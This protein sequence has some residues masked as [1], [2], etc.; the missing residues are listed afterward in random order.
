MSKCF[1][2]GTEIAGGEFG[3]ATCSKCKSCKHPNFWMSASDFRRNLFRCNGCYKVFK[4]V[5]AGSEV[6]V[7]WSGKWIEYDKLVAQEKVEPTEGK[8]LSETN[9][10]RCQMCGTEFESE[11]TN[12][13]YCSPACRVKSDRIK[14]KE[15]K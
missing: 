7:L 13:K 11:R 6:W 9:L 10:K 12:A 14:K 2:H 3:S 5:P 1:I 15:I 8:Q 4:E